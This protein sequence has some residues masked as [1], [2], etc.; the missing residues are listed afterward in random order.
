[1]GDW[2]IFGKDA[3]AQ[4]SKEGKKSFLRTFEGVSN[5]QIKE[6]HLAFVLQQWLLQ[7]NRAIRMYERN[8]VKQYL[9][10]RTADFGNTQQ[11]QD[12]LFRDDAEI[13]TSNNIMALRVEKD[14]IGVAIC[15]TIL[16]KF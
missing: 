4:A 15:D 7:E 9:L 14:K 12:L 10:V 3:A 1:M 6:N 11:V 2:R 5:Y 13:K 16:C 8:E